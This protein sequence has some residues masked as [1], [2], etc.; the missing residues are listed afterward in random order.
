M[1]ARKK[2][3]NCNKCQYIYEVEHIDCIFSQEDISLQLKNHQFYGNKCPSCQNINIDVHDTLYI[4]H[5]HRFIICLLPNFKESDTQ[6]AAILNK[7]LLENKIDND[8]DLKRLTVDHLQFVE[9]INILESELDDRIVE[10]YKYLYKGKLLKDYPDIN[11]ILAYYTVDKQK[12]HLIFIADTAD[13]H[14]EFDKQLYDQIYNDFHI[15]L[16]KDDD[17]LLIDDEW[18]RLFFE[19]LSDNGG[20]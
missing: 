6:Q 17:Y 20:N 13:F 1:L 3:V 4:N 8:F 9:K 12:A 7:L 10:I 2:K 14:V 18:V 19:K 15:V 16:T 11:K 5:Q